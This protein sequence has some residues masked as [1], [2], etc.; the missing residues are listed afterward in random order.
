MAIF[1]TFY[2]NMAILNNG[3]KT[4]M[5]RMLPMHAYPLATPDLDL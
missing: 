1:M 4:N 2:S 3:A 5:T